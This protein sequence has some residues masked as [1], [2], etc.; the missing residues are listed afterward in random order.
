MPLN[1]VSS[2]FA[3]S[4]ILAACLVASAVGAPF[5]M[6]GNVFAQSGDA[7]ATAAP[8]PFDALIL[9]RL[10]ADFQRDGKLREA[11]AMYQ[12]LLNMGG[13]IS[14][15]DMATAAY[16]L[17]RVSLRDGRPERAIDAFDLLLTRYSAFPRAAEAHFLRGRARQMMGQFASAI[18]DW[19]QYLAWRPGIIDSY[20][21][22]M[23]G[24]AQLAL[25]Q[26]AAALES[27]MRAID[28]GRAKVPLLVLREETAQLARR[29]GRFDVALGQYDA[30]LDIA[31]NYGYRAAIAF[32]A[33]RTEMAAGQSDAALQRMLSILERYPQTGVAY[34]ALEILIG[35]GVD[36]DPLRRAQ[37]TFFAGDYAAAIDAINSIVESRSFAE[38]EAE[39][40]LMLGRA[41]RAAGDSGAAM[42][43]FDQLARR[44]PADEQFGEAL[45]ER[46]RTHFL[47][48][49]SETA[50]SVY[51]AIA[52]NYPTLASAAGEALWRAGYLYDSLGD[53]DRSRE[54]FVKLAEKTPN[55]ALAVDGLE[56]AAQAAWDA[57]QWVNAEDLYRR[58]VALT[59]GSQKAESS[60]RL[61]RLALNRGDREAANLD[62][63]TA[64]GAAPETYFAARASDLLQGRQAFAASDRLQ[65]S[66]DE[67]AD[68]RHAEDWLRRTF[69]IEESGE[70]WRLSPALD[71]DPHLRRGRELL[72][73]GLANAASD[74]FEALLDQLRDQRDSLGSYQM[75]VHL[76]TLGAYRESIIAAADVIN[77]SGQGSLDAPVFIARLRFPA[78][79]INLIQAEAKARDIDPL[80]ML[81][82][83]RLESLFNTHA[84]AGAGEKGLM[85][86]IPGTAQYIAD[87]LAWQ[88]YQ[89]RDLFA[90]YAGIAFGAFY[91][92]EQLDLFHQNTIPALAAYNAGPG[93]AWE[94][95]Q[96]AGGDPERFM[97]AISIDST[98]H[99]VRYIYRN[100]NIYRALYGVD[101]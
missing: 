22:E 87:K 59:D 24:A 61:G 53:L 100:Y 92:D 67:S 66:F 85:Q 73:L 76:R 83:I 39:T 14:N 38:T 41:Q 75:A 99:Y 95:N 97:E 46:G 19:R 72:A 16:E 11:A 36:V 44:E 71:S 80:L 13:A 17:G 90:P 18:S 15:D 74:E 57:E 6:A 8:E 50:I 21:H 62:F 52:D 45:L 2:R 42:R 33:A 56:I 63:E 101:S 40:L 82:L 32:D 25:G 5:G 26:D 49:D 31:R 47:A 27:Y 64:I 96:A 54:T 68:A 35:A 78:Y 69:G 37:I 60:L 29:L 89:H 70:L 91:I 4:L 10:G 55:H 65:F 86:V 7:V 43:T 30:V 81:S 88:D 20:T 93:R 28:A 12:E 58:I 77:A 98:R 1:R 48:G 94:W 79:Y 51:L 84:T 34:Q 23:I 3:F 9:L